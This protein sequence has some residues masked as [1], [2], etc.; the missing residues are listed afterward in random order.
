MFLRFI[1][2]IFFMLTVNVAMAQGSCTAPADLQALV[3]GLGQGV[4]ASRQGQ[5]LRALRADRSLMQAAQTHA[6]DI[7]RHGRMTHQGA[8]GTNSAQRAERAGFNTCLTAENLAWGFPR[9][10]QIVAG[11]MGS[12]GHR[13]NILLDRATH[14]GI[15]IA[16]GP[17]GPMWVMLYAR[18]C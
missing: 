6:C 10:E 18:Q 8:D 13:R 7:A 15:G 17:Q 1:L 4:N 12:A 11:W 2:S 16:D 3:N 5:G 9:P 14:Y